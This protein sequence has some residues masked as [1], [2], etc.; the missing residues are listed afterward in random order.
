MNYLSRKNNDLIV[1]QPIFLN[2]A[3]T[4][5]SIKFDHPNGDEIVI[6]Y[7]EIIRPDSHFKIDGLGFY[8]KTT[9][10]NGNIIFNFDIIYPK[11]IDTQR[12]ALIHKLLPKREAPDTSNL[13]CYTLEKTNID[14]TPPNMNETY[15]EYDHINPQQCAQQ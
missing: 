15:E 2:D 14:I 4:G 7:N 11:K 1:K 13:E 9:G 5:L 8:D 10:R 6:E 12:K 3:L